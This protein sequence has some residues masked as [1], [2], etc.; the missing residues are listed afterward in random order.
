VIKSSLRDSLWGSADIAFNN[1]V[2]S[3]EEVRRKIYDM[4]ESQRIDLQKYRNSV[5]SFE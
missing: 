1:A 5:V 4:I 2:C 3:S